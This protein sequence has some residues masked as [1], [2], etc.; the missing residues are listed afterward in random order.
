MIFRHFALLLLFVLTISNAY[1]DCA[2]TY[3]LPD[4]QWHQI[5]LPC[6]APAGSSTA[7][8]ILGDDMGDSAVYNENWVLYAYDAN[9]NAYNNIGTD[10]EMVPA[11]G[12]WIYNG[13]GGTRVLSMPAGSQPVAPVSSLECPAI[14]SSCIETG[15]NYS[16]ERAGESQY[17]MIGIP[18]AE[19]FDWADIHIGDTQTCSATNGSG[20]GCTLEEANASNIFESTAWQYT[21]TAYNVIDSSSTVSTWSGMW[22]D[23]LQNAQPNSELR[24]LLPADSPANA[25]YRVTVGTDGRA[26]MDTSSETVAEDAHGTRIYCPVSHFSYDDP[27]VFPGEPSAAHLHMFWGNTEA[28]AYST[29]GSLLST[30]KASCEGG[31]NNKSAYWAPAVFNAQDEAVLPESVFVYYKSFSHTSGFDRNSIMPIPNGLE[32]LANQQVLNSGP[33]NFVVE[34]RSVNGSQRLHIRISF[35]VCLQVDGNGQPVQSSA[36]NISHLSYSVA[37][38]ETSGDCPASHPYRIPQLIYIINYGVPYYSQWYLSSDQSADTQG[39]SLH[40]DYIA[41]WDEQ[42]MDRIVLCNRLSKESC[43]FISQ[44]NGQSL[45]RTQLPERFL[46][47]QGVPLYS[48]STTLLPETDRT[49]FGSTLGK[50]Q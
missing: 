40:A 6:T 13:T 49:P 20:A 7:A 35:P 43:Q 28:D 37:S 39:S 25:K 1:A 10:G 17:N 36:N 34:P 8:V 18:S 41:A 14:T 32:M 5:S 19:P 23:I 16:A 38:R 27:V 11:V 31:L 29:A 46:S 30:G 47:P 45:A 12:Y 24:L 4:K 44:E 48:D 26:E 33:W 50:M 3:T 22:V 9:S 15:L 42:T 2:D 21:G